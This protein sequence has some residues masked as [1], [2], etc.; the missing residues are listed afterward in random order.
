VRPSK[1]SGAI[2]VAMLVLMADGTERNQIRIGIVSSVASELL[3]MHFEVRRRTAELASPTI[4]A[5][6][7]QPLSLV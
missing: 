5:E 2:A 4:A 3:M 6:Y 7:R 1:W